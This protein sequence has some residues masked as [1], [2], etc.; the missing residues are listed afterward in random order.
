[1]IGLGGGKAIALDIDAKLMTAPIF[2][3]NDAPTSAATV[4]Y[5][6]EGQFDGWATFPLKHCET[7]PKPCARPNKSLTIM[8]LR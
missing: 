4:Y 3:S 5:T 7:L 8:Y 6:E 1:M 2:A